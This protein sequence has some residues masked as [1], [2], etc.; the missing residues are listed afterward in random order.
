[1]FESH[2]EDEL[3]CSNFPKAEIT[4]RYLKFL[5]SHEIKETSIGVIT[6]FKTQVKKIKSS[7]KSQD[8]LVGR[9]G[10]FQGQERDVIVLSLVRSNEMGDIEL[11][12]EMERI[13]FSIT[14]AKRHL[15]IICDSK[16]MSNHDLLRDFVE[17]LQLKAKVIPAQVLQGGLEDMAKER[18]SLQ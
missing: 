5:I 16:T 14:R 10:R 18:S 3:L 17:F 4:T 9:P 11:F 7:I 13:N 8:I 12:T 6:P 15:A 2:P 1:M